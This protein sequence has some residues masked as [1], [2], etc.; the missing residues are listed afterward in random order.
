VI[1]FTPEFVEREYN[2]RAACPDHPQWFAEYARLSAAAYA[3]LD[4]RRELRYG[5]GPQETLDLFLPQGSVRGTFV[6]LHGGYWRALD[7]ADFAFVAGPFVAR[8]I[9]VANVNY[10]LCP[11]VTVAAIVAECRRA[12]GWIAREGARHGA[13][14]RRIVVGG[15]SAG[16]HLAA[17][18]FCT[19]WQ[20]QGFARPP[21]HAGV[22]LSGVHDLTPMPLF[23]F[24]SDLRLDEAGARALSPVFCP[25]TMVAPL[26]M[27]VGGAETAEFQRQT[28]LLWE[29]WPAHR[30][31]GAAA[32]LVAAGKNHFSVV[33]DYADPDSEL[34]RATLAL[35]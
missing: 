12:V 11:E 34:T 32:P 27:A 25:L 17:M 20:A 33:A 2:N 6:F 16:G 15:H 18:M 29:A 31:A 5:A 13:D 8:G 35:F 28:R 4:L 14:A 3:S 7:K 1:P 26:L 21:L 24:N 23:S 10:D 9:A 30:P 22:T 19:D